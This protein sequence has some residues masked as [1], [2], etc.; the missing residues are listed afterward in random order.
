M[1]ISFGKEKAMKANVYTME[2]KIKELT[3]LHTYEQ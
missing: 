1:D 2:R 3:K